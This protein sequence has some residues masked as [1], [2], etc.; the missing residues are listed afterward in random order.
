MNWACPKCR[1]PLQEFSSYYKCENN[2]TFDIAKQGYSNLLL[3][4]QKSS[5]NPGDNDK[6][7]MARSSF[8]EGNYFKP[9][10]DEIVQLF[11]FYLSENGI[12]KGTI[13]D[14]GCGEGHY[15]RVLSNSLGSSFQYKG[16]DIAKK[17]VKLAAAGAK[18]D[19]KIKSDFAVASSANIPLSDNSCVAVYSIFSPVKA[20]EIL[21]I[22]KKQGCFIRVLP[23]PNHLYELKE[24]IYR[25]ARQ[26]D[27]PK[28]LMGFTLISEKKL[29]FDLCFDHGE[30]YQNLIEMT[31]FAW[32][33]K[34]KSN[35]NSLFTIGDKITADFNIQVMRTTE[36]LL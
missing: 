25:E 1:L 5:K 9:L 22:L 15:L 30:T 35:G 10:Q 21:R 19:I 11:K 2:H 13:L 27:P 29:H 14:C 23:G 32:E 6:M 33:A 18:K 34:L 3:A 26:H 8:L 24:K 31:P 16:I 12:S 20:L 36:S 17:G 4:N 7:L 28:E